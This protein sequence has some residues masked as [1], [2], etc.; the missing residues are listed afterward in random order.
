M[1]AAGQ[2]V[3]RPHDPKQNHPRSNKREA[4]AAATLRSRQRD[5]LDH[6]LRVVHSVCCLAGS[7]SLIDDLRAE[8]RVEGV[9][10][11]IRR[12]DTGT[13]FD[14]LIAALSYQGISDRVASGYMDR[15]G[16]ARWCDINAKLSRGATCPKLQSYWHYHR[17]R[18]DKISRTCAEP[19]HIDQC[20][21]PSHDLR[22]GRLNQTAYSLY[23]FIRDIADGDLVDWI[24][25]Q[26]QQADQPRY[27]DRP[28]RLREALIEPLREVYGV[29]DKV[30]TMTLSCVLLAAPRGYE[31]WR[32]VGATMIAIDTLVHNFLHRTGILARF[33]ADHLYG[34]GCYRPGGCADIIALVAEQIDAR[35][36]NPAFPAVFP[37]FVQHAIWRYCAQAGL[38][39]CN[40]NRIDDRRRCRNVYC[41]IRTLCDRVALH[42]AK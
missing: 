33:G 8:P 17:C 32:Q 31:T 20:P 9:P 36:F 11:A 18:Y 30:L 16:R 4:G 34:A 15:H 35:A 41:Q 27:T 23:L 38:A 21:V 26:F 29:S 2:R 19:D 5:A 28:A 13:L 10:S 7:A 3:R 1:M 14:W 25:R 12:H 6:A 22:N 40:G 42:K 39:V 24:D 37:R